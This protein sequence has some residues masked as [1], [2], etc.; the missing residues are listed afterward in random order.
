MSVDRSLRSSS[1]LSRHRNVLS[2]TERIAKLVDKGDFDM[3]DSDPLG[4]VKVAN[5]K[6]VTSGKTKKAKTEEEAGDAAAS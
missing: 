1:S 6:I 4:L 2:R 5:R 3:K